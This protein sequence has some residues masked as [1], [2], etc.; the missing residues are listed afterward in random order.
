MPC[1]HQ[2]GPQLL[3]VQGCRQHPGAPGQCLLVPFLWL[4][5]AS[6]GIR[7]AFPSCSPFYAAMAWP[8]HSPVLE[9][10]PQTKCHQL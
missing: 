9:E 1:T 2:V 5:Q 6:P 8:S 10:A 7:T 4:L 3:L